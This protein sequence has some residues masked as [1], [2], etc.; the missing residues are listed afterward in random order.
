M[1]AFDLDG[2]LFTDDKRITQRTW[3]ALQI[4]VEKGVLLVPTTGR[5]VTGLP[6]ALLNNDNIR[7]VISANGSRII[8]NR[9]NKIIKEDLI[10]VKLAKRV[11][12]ILMKYDCIIDIYYDGMGY[13]QESFHER[14]NEFHDN[15]AV[16]QYYRETRRTVPDIMQKFY[17]ESRPVD[18]LQGTFLS[19]E[20]RSRAR[21]EITEIKDIK[22]T[23]S[24]VNNL[25]MNLFTVNKGTAM[26]YLGEQLGIHSIEMMAIGDGDNDI[27]M[28][29]MAGTGIAM[30]NA[31]FELK[32]VA[33]DITDTNEEDGFAKAIEKYI[34]D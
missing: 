26:V 18:K 2:T 7:Y 12:D 11:L 15:P 25:E 9:D 8:D 10:D 16:A 30:G 22:I 13:M 19:M 29:E 6:S 21:E 32:K 17:E 34:A 1:F 24:I 27:E 4:A 5:P 14:V 20:D 28:V 3:D 33:N 23:S 31:I